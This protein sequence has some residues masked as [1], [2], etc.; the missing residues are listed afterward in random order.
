MLPQD[1]IILY[2]YKERLC[3]NKLIY[4]ALFHKA[5]EGGFWVSFPDFPECLTQGT[6]LWNAYEMARDAVKLAIISRLENGEPLPAST[7]IHI[8]TSDTIS[9]YVDITWEST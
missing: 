9:L 3:M 4:S 8:F 1:T 2:L 7:D 5:D 6:S